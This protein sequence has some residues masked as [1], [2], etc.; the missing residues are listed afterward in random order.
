MT[1]NQGPS[2]QVTP[3]TLALQAIPYFAALGNEIVVGIN[4]NKAGEVLFVRHVVMFA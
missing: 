2:D 4:N 1:E 3:K